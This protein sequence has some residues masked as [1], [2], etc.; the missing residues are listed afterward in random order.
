MK[1]ETAASLI[2]GEAARTRKDSDEHAPKEKG[3][4]FSSA[5]TSVRMPPLGEEAAVSIPEMGLS[6]RHGTSLKLMADSSTFLN[7]S[8]EFAEVDPS[9]D[10]E[11]W[12]SRGQ[13]ASF[14]LY[15]I[16]V[17]DG[18]SMV[19]CLR[20]VLDGFPSPQPPHRPRLVIDYVT[21]RPEHRGRG[22]ATLLTR[23]VA[24]AASSC[25]ANL[26]VLALEE[27]CVYWMSLGFIL[28]EGQNLNA[29]LNI[30]PDTHLLTRS[31]DPEDPGSEEDLLLAPP[32]QMEGNDG[33][34]DS[35]DEDEDEDE[36]EEFDEEAYDEESI[37]RAIALSLASNSDAVLQDATRATDDAMKQDDDAEDDDAELR[38]A[39]ALSLEA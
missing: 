31:G 17:M 16:A 26:Y 38:A 13:A 32:P 20:A 12:S 27:S 15:Y 28:A 33:E 11:K 6:L 22:I 10:W 35:E 5:D 9:A 4:V 18:S 14:S 29:R 37:Q 25:N 21:T 8:E 30:F 2:Q 36:D 3:S 1:V 19:A 39:L 23:F 34:E 24:A 7:A